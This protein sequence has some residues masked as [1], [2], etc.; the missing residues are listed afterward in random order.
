MSFSETS[1]KAAAK[2]WKNGDSTYT[3]TLNS[4]REKSRNKSLPSKRKKMSATITLTKE[5]NEKAGGKTRVR[6]IFLS[7]P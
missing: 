6:L 1:A 2:K 4:D 3:R 7:L 5:C